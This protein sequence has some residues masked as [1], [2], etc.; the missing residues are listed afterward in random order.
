[1]PKGTQGMTLLDN[2]IQAPS[3]NGAYTLRKTDPRGFGNPIYENFIRDINYASKIEQ[4]K[5]DLDRINNNNF[6]TLFEPAT[7]VIDTSDTAFE[8][9][10]TNI[11]TQIS[12]TD[13]A[14]TVL[15][16]FE[17]QIELSSPLKKELDVE[18]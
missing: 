16:V 6:I 1:M 13:A 9:F 14:F 10:L 2:L 17:A 7:E 8:T 4:L 15:N 5:N 18:A 11:K 12:K 3:K